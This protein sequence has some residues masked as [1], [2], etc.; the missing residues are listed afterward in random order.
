MDV[1]PWLLDSDP[2]VRWQVLADL[3]D[4]PAEQ[5]AAERA[6]VATQGWGAALL[7][8]QGADGQWDGGT[9]RPGWVDDAKPFFDAWTATTYVL[10]DLVRLGLDPASPQARHAVGLVRDGS[11]WE[12]TGTPFFAGETEPCING[13]T[14]SI[15]SHFGEDVARVVDRLLADQLPDGGWNCWAEY[16]ATVSSFH[17]TLTVLEG[18]HAWQQSGGADVAVE[19]ARRR[20]EAYLLDRRLYRRLTTGTVVDPRYTMFSWPTR[21]YYDVLR[22]LD[23]LRAAGRRD[24]RASE[25]VAMVRDK[26]EPDG[27]WLLENTH[28][29]PTHVQMEGPD[30][31]ASRW[32][33][34]RALRV[35]RWWDGPRTPPGP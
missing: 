27:T 23:H 10:L 7:E 21:W 33:T 25:A 17:S 5:V 16:G 6:R 34:L 15:G 32:N 12:A 20:G 8:L 11:R 14:V 19:E 13:M 35:L 1:L 26:R 3:V 22:A 2:A 30:G 18:L 9:Y 29:G 28:G 4:A 24:P 31:V